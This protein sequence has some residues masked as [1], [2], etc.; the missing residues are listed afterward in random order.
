LYN[1][2]ISLQKVGR[3]QKIQKYNFNIKKQIYIIFDK[4]TII[5]GKK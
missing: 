2:E 1:I 5:L 4:M 3:I